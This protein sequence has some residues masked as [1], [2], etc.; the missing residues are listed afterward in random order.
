[1]EV[2]E[3]PLQS[4]YLNPVE[5]LWTELKRV[6][7]RRRRILTELNQFCQEE[8]V[9]ILAKYQEKLEE[10]K[11]QSLVQ[12][13]AIKKSVR[14]ESKGVCKLSARWKSDQVCE[15]WNESLVDII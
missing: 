2:L 3:W 5:D 6:W 14:E 7:A 1:M 15:S 4:P 8:W 11:S 9:E 13:Q 10:G 12:V